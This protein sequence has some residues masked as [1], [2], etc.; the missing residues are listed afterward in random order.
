MQCVVFVATLTYSNATF[1]KVLRNQGMELFLQ[2]VIDACEYFGA[3]APVWVPDCTK[4]GVIKGSRTDWAIL[5]SSM[6][7]LARAYGAEVSAC[8]PYSPNDDDSSD[9]SFH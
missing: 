8:S 3:V 2:S 7:E 5:N 6:E 9:A 1:V 4:S